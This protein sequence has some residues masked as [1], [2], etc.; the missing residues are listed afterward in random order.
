MRSG[1]RKG[2]RS[3][4]INRCVAAASLSVAGCAALSGVDGGTA[5]RGTFRR[6]EVLDA[7]LLVSGG[8]LA[9]AAAPE[10]DAGADAGGIADAGAA[11]VGSPAADAPVVAAEVAGAIAAGGAAVDPCVLSP[12]AVDAGDAPAVADG[13]DGDVAEDAAGAASDVVSLLKRSA[14]ATSA[15]R[16]SICA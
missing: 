5:L 16:G 1:G 12:S 9:L 13:D 8:V 4:S 11:S 10:A 3:R 2:P 6:R 14:R 7:G 15:T